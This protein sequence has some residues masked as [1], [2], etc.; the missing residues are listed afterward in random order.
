MDR[1]HLQPVQEIMI[2]P[3][4]TQCT[5]GCGLAAA[6]AILILTVNRQRRLEASDV[7]PFASAFLS[8]SNLPAAFY[9]SWYGF[10]PDPPTVLTKLHGFEKYVAFAGLTFLLVNVV[11]LWALFRHAYVATEELKAEGALLKTAPNPGAA[12]D[13]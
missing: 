6:I 11:A 5:V 8:G 3:N 4:F 12:P 10:A 9:L 7:G 13:G 2:V 1:L